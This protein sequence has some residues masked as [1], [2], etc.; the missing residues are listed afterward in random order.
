MEQNSV[1]GIIVTYNIGNNLYK[2]FN[3]IEGQV[4]KLVIVD[5]GSNKETIDVLKEI[6]KNNN[7]VEVI[8]N[9]NNLGIGKALNQGVE[10][11]IKN[12]FQ[13]VLTMDNDS[14]ATTSMVEIMINTY[15]KAI[16]DGRKNIVS[17]FP[18]YIEK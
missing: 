7:H 2:C 14:E 5:N 8:Y 10:V 18:T 4:E 12:N 1:C 11:A 6:E 3:S 16:N 13:W 15:N 17:I 9:E